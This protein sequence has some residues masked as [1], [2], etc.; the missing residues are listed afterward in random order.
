MGGCSEL[1]VKY[2]GAAARIA[3]VF[4]LVFCYSSW[5]AVGVVF[6]G[7]LG[8]AATYKFKLQTQQQ[9]NITSTNNAACKDEY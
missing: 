2:I 5:C 6:C 4:R 3:L 9:Y 1:Y 7:G 8:Q